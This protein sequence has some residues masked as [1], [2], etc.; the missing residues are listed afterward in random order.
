MILELINR[1]PFCDREATI[2]AQ[3]YHENPYCNECLNDR[4]RLASEAAPLIRWESRGNYSTPIRASQK[5]S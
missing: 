4:I 1:C 3:E 5:V 2:P